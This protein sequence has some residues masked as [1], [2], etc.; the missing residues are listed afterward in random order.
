M[1]TIVT[2]S[3]QIFDKTYRNLHVFSILL[4]FNPF[5]LIF[6]HTTFNNLLHLSLSFCTTTDLIR[7]STAQKT[8]EQINKRNKDLKIRK[9]DGNAN[10]KLKIYYLRGRKIYTHAPIYSLSSAIRP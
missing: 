9:F 7:I 6:V 4:D 10:R 5:F 1:Q 3:D 2:Q 8:N